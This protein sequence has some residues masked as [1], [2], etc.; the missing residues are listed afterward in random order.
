MNT[1][2][3]RTDAEVAGY[4]TRRELRLVTAHKVTGSSVHEPQFES[5]TQLDS[6][7]PHDLQCTYMEIVSPFGAQDIVSIRDQSVLSPVNSMEYPILHCFFW[8]L[9][10]PD[11]EVSAVV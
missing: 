7:S 3:V 5:M 2:A 11:M 4:L 9:A 6:D 8:P 10:A 1:C